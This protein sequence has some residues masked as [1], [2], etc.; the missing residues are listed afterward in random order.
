MTSMSRTL[1]P[2]EVDNFLARGGM[3]EVYH[4]VHRAERHAAAIKVVSAD[5]AS[6]RAYADALLDEVRAA[7]SLNHPSIVALLDY[8]EVRSDEA[9]ASDGLFSVGSPWFAMEYATVGTLEEMDAAPSWSVLRRILAE[10]LDALAHAHARGIV[11]RDLKPANVLATRREDRVALLLADFGIAHV[12]DDESTVPERT[13]EIESPSAGTPT[14]MAPEQ[15]RGQWRDWGPWTDL[16]AVGCMGWKLATGHPPFDGRSPIEIGLKQVTEEPPS[17]DPVIPVPPEFETWLRRLL[18][19][20]WWYRYRRAADAAWALFAMGGDAAD[21]SLDVLLEKGSS[22][23]ALLEAMVTQPLG[24][25]IA[26][27]ATIDSVM[28]QTRLLPSVRVRAVRAEDASDAEYEPTERPPIPPDWRSAGEGRVRL[29]R[30]GL[31]LFGV[32]EIPLV[33]RNAVRDTLWAALG[34]AAEGPGA[35][36]VVIES[37][38]GMGKTKLLRW[39]GTRAHEVGA[40]EV[41]HANHASIAGL[42]DGLPRMVARHLGCEG[43]DRSATFRRIREVLAS[44]HRSEDA[45]DQ[46]AALTQLVEP[47]GPR[48]HDQVPPVQFGSPVERYATVERYLRDEAA[49]RPVVLAVDDAQ[50]GHDVLAFVEHLLASTSDRPFPVVVVLAVRTEE[51][52]ERELEKQRLERLRTF[53]QT[54]SVTLGALNSD[55]H[56]ELV[57]ELLGLDAQLSHQLVQAADGDPMYSIC[58]VADWVQRGVLTAGPRGYTIDESADHE[59]PRSVIDICEARFDRVAATCALPA[60]ARHVLQVAA[61][62]GETIDEEEWRGLCARRG[63]AVPTGFVDSLVDAGLARPVE[64]GWAFVH[65][66]L[67]EALEREA[68]RR[69]IWEQLHTDCA[70]AVD[71]A[72]QNGTCAS[73]R[74][75]RHFLEAGRLDEALAQLT[76]AVE[77]RLST[78]AYEEA[79]ALT[80]LYLRQL[81]RHDRP[82]NTEEV[83][84]VLAMRAEA[85]RYVGKIERASS[86]AHEI[87][88][89]AKAMDSE[90]ARAE[91]LRVLGGL[92][93]RLGDHRRGIELY[94]EAMEHYERAGDSLGISRCAHGLGWLYLNRGD[95]RLGMESFE[96][97]VEITRRLEE[98]RDLAWG[99]QGLAE[100]SL[101]L[102]DVETAEHAALEALEVAREIG[103]RSAEGM[104]LTTVGNLHQRLGRFDEADGHYRAATNMFGSIDSPLVSFAMVHRMR[105]AM[106]RDEPQMFNE[107][108]AAMRFDRIP[109]AFRLSYHLFATYVCAA[110]SEAEMDEVLDGLRGELTVGSYGFHPSMRDFPAAVIERVEELMP[111]RVAEV[112]ELVEELESRLGRTVTSR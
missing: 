41:L 8:G 34:D 99:L 112:R 49:H 92:Q 4:A 52:D 78:S 43:L 64:E 91:G 55:D 66:V 16:Y 53:V 95:A 93:H 13:D 42:G 46:A 10:V 84:R 18:E 22:T 27:M 61:A 97:C 81:D 86:I 56:L 26:S 51:L 31:G 28:E 65:G 85:F 105:L 45:V 15:F 25:D 24:D 2:F 12:V 73:E 7:A 40:A 48:A 57:D 35:R 68:R 1:G 103:S 82:R 88:S 58:V 69:G 80:D 17:F 36:V 23:D 79:L 110:R 100:A 54:E 72:A 108:F 6:D 76:K 111:S 74:K 104:S 102:D 89:M 32:R 62:L 109:M 77:R 14:F 83:A 101:Y 50:F 38:S 75:A 11:H 67:R 30:T 90:L 5:V 3:G 44:R 98:E 94:R 19:K 107:L 59:L 63:V 70:H 33:D 29:R 9:L 87:V 106:R 21:P 37:E 39:F 96:R 20:D 71:R 47:A 60:N